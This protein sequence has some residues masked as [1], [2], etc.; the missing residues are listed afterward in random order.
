MD[1]RYPVGGFVDE[2]DDQE[3]KAEV[4]MTLPCPN[5]CWDGETIF[6]PQGES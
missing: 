3:R 6:I 5:V 1:D 2:N 4:D